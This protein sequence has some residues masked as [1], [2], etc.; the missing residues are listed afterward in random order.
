MWLV[1]ALTAAA[2]LACAVTIWIALQNS[3]ALPTPSTADAAP[4]LMPAL[5]A[6]NAVA[7]RNTI[8]QSKER[9]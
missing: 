6:R 5:Q 4:A 8:F 3:D 1:V 7:D 9:D 2:L